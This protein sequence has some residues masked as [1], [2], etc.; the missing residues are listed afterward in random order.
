MNDKIFENIKLVSSFQELVAP[1]FKNKTN[2]I[3]WK[4]NLN[5]NF[6]EI[7]SKINPTDNITEI[8][9]EILLK[10]NLSPLGQLARETILNDFNLLKK[11]GAR[12]N[13]NI[14]KSYDRD[15]ENSIILTDVYSFHVDSSPVPTDT[16]LCTYFGAASEILPNDQAIQKVLIPSI[17]N[18]LLKQYGINKEGFELYLSENFY[19]LHYKAKANA[20]IIN[21]GLGNMW[22]LATAHPKSKVLPCIHRAPKEKDG[23]YRLMIIC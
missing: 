12:P 18:E 10:L 13:L 22:R 1:Q 20:N 3:C 16:F 5:G 15:N 6:Q 23:E 21:L 8:N 7:V 17:R 11:H 2:A 9:D 4:R 14:I 19:D